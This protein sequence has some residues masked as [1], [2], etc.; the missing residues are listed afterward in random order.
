MA[1]EQQELTVNFTPEQ[2]TTFFTNQNQGLGI[3]DRARGYLTAEGFGD[4]IALLECD[5]D[6]IDTLWHNARRPTGTEADPANPNQQIPT[7]PY[8]LNAK[9]KKRLKAVIRIL[10]FY[11]KVGR[12]VTPSLLA[13]RVV[14]KFIESWT[15][16]EEKIAE[17][18]TKIPRVDKKT[19][20][21]RNYEDWFMTWLE[22]NVGK[23]G[24]Q[25]TYVVRKD[26]VP[27]TP[28]PPTAPGEAFSEEFGSVQDELTARC[29]HRH[30]GFQEDNAA[31]FDA[32]EQGLRG[33]VFAPTLKQ[34]ARKKNG[35]GAWLAILSNYLG[36]DK[37]RQEVADVEDALI[38]NNWRGDGP[39]TLESFASSHRGGHERLKAASLR[40]SFQLPDEQ[41]KVERFLNAITCT[42]PELR[43]AIAQV[44]ANRAPDGPLYNFDECVAQLLPAC[45][46]AKKRRLNKGGKRNDIL[47][48][49]IA[50]VELERTT[51]KTGIELGRYYTSAEYSKLTS[52]QKNELRLYRIAKGLK[53]T[54]PDEKGNGG[55]KRK[56][57]N[58]DQLSKKQIKTM[59][60]SV[61]NAVKAQLEV[62]A[63]RADEDAKGANVSSVAMEKKEDSRKL[64]DPALAKVAAVMG[65]L[66]SNALKK[67]SKS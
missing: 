32:L 62:P 48:A 38:N 16:I 56:N 7:R 58:K 8:N 5:D 2:V 36:E 29:T 51:G 54:K 23:A 12:T 17:E 19:T 21:L 59:V 60:D 24:A 63:K 33:T 13:W 11:K 64:N 57:E 20:N 6:T 37:W 39:T 53:K 65:Q 66:K 50:A 28:L 18:L 42:D 49:H 55:K 15:I 14:S 43:A 35:R 30:A 52:E 61:V 26:S 3:Q 40:T 45:P 47:K 10:Q 22:T 67:G 31:V 44:K 41:R 1:E 25:L 46:V 34:F 9:S 27:L 4:I